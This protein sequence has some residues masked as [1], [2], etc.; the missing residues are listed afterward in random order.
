LRVAKN[1]DVESINNF[2]QHES[3]WLRDMT[4]TLHVI[5]K[6]RAY[7]NCSYLGSV[8]G[9]NFDVVLENKF[10]DEMKTYYLEKSNEKHNSINKFSSAGNSSNLTL[11][12]V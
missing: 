3:I 10:F 1:C 4:G 7:K 12:K 9:A 5:I 2:K 6:D 8:E 11:Q